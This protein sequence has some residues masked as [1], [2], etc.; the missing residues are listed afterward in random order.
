M[1]RLLFLMLILAFLLSAGALPPQAIT[2]QAPAQTVRLI[3]IHHSTGENWL[4]DENGGLGKALD[5]AHY[6]VSDT[7][8]GWGPEG[9]GDR[10][11]IPNWTEWFRGPNSAAI[12][13]ALYREN[14]QN[15]PYT[16]TLAD[17]GGENE[18]ILFKS[19][20]PNSALEGSP[21]DPPAAGEGLTVSHAKYVYNELLKYFVTRPDKLFVLIT[22]PPLS[23][24]SLSANARAFN[25]WLM[26][27]WLK[28]YPLKNVAVFDFYTVLTGANHHH[29]L[30]NGAIEHVFSPGRNTAY[31]PSEDDHPSRAGNLKATQEFVPLLNY[32]YQRWKESAPASPAA[33]P[34]PGAAPQA[35]TEAPAPAPAPAQPSVPLPPRTV[36][37]I[38]DFEGGKPAGT[39][40]WQAFRDENPATRMACTPNSEDFKA[41]KQ[42]LKLD[43][44][45]ASGSWATCAL[46]FEN[47]QDWSAGDSLGFAM[48]LGQ[49]GTAIEVALYS[50]L[51]EARE[52]YLY[53]AEPALYAEEEWI[54]YVV[55][56]QD[57]KRAEWE[58][59]G[60][61]PFNKMKQVTGMAFVVNGG[62][63]AANTGMVRIDEVRLLNHHA[64]GAQPT[65][66]PKPAQPTPAQPAE[67]Q[68]ATQPSSAQSASKPGGLPVCGSIFALPLA[69][70]AVVF[71]RRRRT[72]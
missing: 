6:F 28:D 40:D 17:P 70:L 46:M 50:G 45:V 29:R 25:E 60:G 36:G 33:K 4:S 22:A 71:W 5:Q 52:T 72:F 41:G 49:P 30:V 11:D 43:F 62:E 34:Q 7:N 38:D 47:D 20:F 53:H 65:Q 23:D 8:Y 19:C 58:T 56:W 63:S 54:S 37:V 1:K 69:G 35:A 2:P 27:T 18:V 48:R 26:E 51:A 61:T 31:Y 10:T 39:P 57:F 68:S 15:A 21:N 67:Q 24:P 55:R 59:N 66:A 44:S 14:G 16:R 13:Q 64:A 3:F 42:A 12:L 9:I 32:F